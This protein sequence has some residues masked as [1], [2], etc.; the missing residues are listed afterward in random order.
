MRF[1]LIMSIQSDGSLDANRWIQDLTIA[2]AAVNLPHQIHA[3]YDCAKH[4][5]SLSV[6]VSLTAKIQLRLI[7]DTNEQIKQL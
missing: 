3:L 5:K 7:A 6:R 1:V 2:R 4:R